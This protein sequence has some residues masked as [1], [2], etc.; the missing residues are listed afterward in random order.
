VRADSTLLLYV[1]GK[2]LSQAPFAPG[3][4]T[5]TDTFATGDLY[6]GAAPGGGGALKGALD[7]VRVFPAALTADELSALHASDTAPAGRTPVLWLPF[8]I[9]ADRSSPQ[10]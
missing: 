3:S 10:M 4:L 2:P 5:R 9:A 1:D 8:D 6:L 7:D